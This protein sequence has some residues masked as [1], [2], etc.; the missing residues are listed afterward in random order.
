MVAMVHQLV[1]IFFKVPVLQ[2]QYSFDPFQILTEYSNCFNPSV[3]FIIFNEPVFFC[4]LDVVLDKIT[5]PFSRHAYIISNVS[6]FTSEFSFRKCIVLVF[7]SDNR[8]NCSKIASKNQ[9]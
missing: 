7:F 1:N 9:F 4:L 8:C 2:T 5:C 3:D 6:E